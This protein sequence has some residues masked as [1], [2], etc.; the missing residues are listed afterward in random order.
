MLLKK[1][2]GI[3]FDLDDTLVKTK[4]EYVEETVN[5]TLKDLGCEKKANKKES[6]LFWYGNNRNEKIKKMWGVNP[7]NFWHTFKKYDT[8]EGR[9]KYTEI[10]EDIEALKNLENGI[11]I[12]ILTSSIK[13]IALA[14]KKLVD[15][16]LNIG[17]FVVANIFENIEEKPDPEGLYKCLDLLK[18]KPEEAMMV[19]DSAHDILAAQ[20]SNVLDILVK[21]DTKEIEGCKPTIIIPDLYELTKY[22]T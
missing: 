20:S 4:T 8:A 17:C 9:I 15:P 13:E 21:R 22:V 19:G 2:K 5:A 12:G 3:I 16:Y 14:E 6:S 7:E 10:Y 18:I 11:K 1:I